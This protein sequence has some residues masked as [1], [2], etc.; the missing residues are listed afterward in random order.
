MR[1]LVSTLAAL[2]FATDTLV[3]KVSATPV[4]CAPPPP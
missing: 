2:P 4:F 1:T 3:D